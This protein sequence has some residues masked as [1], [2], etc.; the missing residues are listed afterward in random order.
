MVRSFGVVMSVLFGSR[1]GSGVA[2][3]FVSTSC[4]A[5]GDGSADG[6]TLGAGEGVDSGFRA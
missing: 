4:V 6:L 5:L 2:L 1:V 3:S